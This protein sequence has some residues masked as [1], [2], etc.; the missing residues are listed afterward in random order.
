MTDDTELDAEDLR[1]EL[2]QIKEAMGL[3]ERYP[4][5]FQAWLVYAG[6]VLLAS[7]VSQ[8]IVTF[9]LPPWGHPVAWF[10]LIGVGV[11]YGRYVL[12]DDGT[13]GDAVPSIRV[14]GLAVAGYILAVLVAVGPLLDGA[15]EAVGTATQFG[16]IL[17][18]VGVYYLLVGSSLRAYRVRAR[19][20]YA[21]YAGGAW[22]LAYAAAMPRV[23]VLQE[24]GYAVFGIL[25]AL[26]GVGSYVA[27]RDG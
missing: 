19:D 13:T 5:Q 1:A 10:G 2:N 14:Q 22:I 3:H 27:L 20:R 7:L 9:E 23:D 18:G 6:L 17:G 8:A 25:F 4:S 15:G 16:L 11:A 21:F 26:H 12:P 24:W